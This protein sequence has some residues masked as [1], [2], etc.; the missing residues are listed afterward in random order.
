MDGLA[1]RKAVMERWY[2][3]KSVLTSS[4]GSSD[5]G[6]ASFCCRRSTTCS[7]HCICRSRMACT[8]SVTLMPGS[9]A[10]MRCHPE[11]AMARRRSMKF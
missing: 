3:S 2:S 5:S 7:A 6:E 4:A 9:P 11:R 8:R 1:L 10:T